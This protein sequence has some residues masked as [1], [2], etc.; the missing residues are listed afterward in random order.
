MLKRATR[1]LVRR[2]SSKNSS[3]LQAVISSLCGVL[4]QLLNLIYKDSTSS[5]SQWISAIRCFRVVVSLATE[6]SP[7]KT[8]SSQQIRFNRT[9]RRLMQPQKFDGTV[10]MEMIELIQMGLDDLVPG[11]TE[12]LLIAACTDCKISDRVPSDKN[13]FRWFQNA[14]TNRARISCLDILSKNIPSFYMLRDIF[15]AQPEI[16]FRFA[17]ETRHWSKEEGVKTHGVNIG[18]NDE[19]RS[20]HES[21]VLR[22]AFLTLTE[23]LYQFCSKDKTSSLCELSRAIDRIESINSND[24]VDRY[25]LFCFVQGFVLDSY[26]HSSKDD[27]NTLRCLCTYWSEIVQKYKVS[28]NVTLPYSMMMR[29]LLLHAIDW[30]SLPA[31]STSSS[32]SSSCCICESLLNESV[33]IRRD[34]YLI[35]I[36]QATPFLVQLAKGQYLRLD[37][38]EGE[39]D[40][41]TSHAR[42]LAIAILSSVKR[43]PMLLKWDDEMKFGTLMGGLHQDRFDDD[44]EDEK[45]DDDDEME[46]HKEENDIL[47]VALT[48]DGDLVE[49]LAISDVS[50]HVKEFCSRISILQF[51]MSKPDTYNRF[52]LDFLREVQNIGKSSLIREPSRQIRYLRRYMGKEKGE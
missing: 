41:H 1:T 18:E 39:Y 43:L 32:S 33:R 6:G 45:Q 40:T 2:N 17:C 13:V 44:D 15:L 25:E 23:R 24:S 19:N 14:S 16:L 10:L 38:H 20:R 52:L 4:A 7:G 11:T 48:P 42:M 21:V 46:E 8:S 22:N 29:E 37:R 31:P 3:W 34:A 12:S 5:S 47:E 50:R 26:I 36:E 35:I 28:S 27:L 9:F 51:R 49:R 30:S